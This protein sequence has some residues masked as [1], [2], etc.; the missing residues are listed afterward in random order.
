[1]RSEGFVIGSALMD[2]GSHAM[3]GNF[4][5]GFSVTVNSFDSWCHKLVVS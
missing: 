3:Q 2:R 1:M 4:F 5:V